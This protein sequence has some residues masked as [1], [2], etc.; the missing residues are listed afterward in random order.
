MADTVEQFIR[1]I[2]PFF[3][4]RNVTYVDVGAFDGAVSTKFL[5]SSLS[6]GEAHLIE[7]NPQSFERLK[8]TMQEMSGIGSLN[9]YNT[10]IGERQTTT[11]M[12]MTR[13][14]GTSD[15]PGPEAKSDNTFEVECL[16]LDEISDR[17]V[18]GEI[19]ILKV[20]VEGLERNALAGARALL[21]EGRVDVLYI[22]AGAD[23]QGT[24]RCFYRDINDIMLGHDYRIFRIYEQ[25]HDWIED[26][27][28]LRRMSIAYLS[29]R[30]AE[31][32]PYRLTR[33][34]FDAQ[35]A[36]EGAR[37]DLAAES[38][39]ATQL[40][41]W[42]KK[43]KKQ[44]EQGVAASKQKAA[45]LHEQVKSQRAA[46][47]AEAKRTAQLESG[48]IKL[49]RL[50][51][52]AETL[53]KSKASTLQ[54]K[55]AYGKDTIEGLKKQAD[56]DRQAIEALAETARKTKVRARNEVA[57]LQESLARKE[58]R[59]TELNKQLERK[60]AEVQSLKAKIDSIYT[61]VSWRLAAPVRVI[62]GGLRR[63]RPKGPKKSKAIAAKSVGTEPKSKKSV[64]AV[65]GEAASTVAE[66]PFLNTPK[67]EKSTA[68]KQKKPV[69][70]GKKGS[71]SSHARQL[72]D[73]LWGGFSR[74]ALADLEAVKRSSSTNTAEIADAAKAL[75]CWY[76]A[77]NDFPRGRENAALARSILNDKARK[78]HVLVE[79]HCLVR[80][81]DGA[82][83]RQLL[84][85]LLETYPDDPNVLFA[86][87]STYIGSD[88]SSDADD[89]RLS[90]INR[91]YKQAN[92]LPLAK[93]DAGGALTI[94]NLT[95]PEPETVDH[96]AKV[97]IIVPAF[98]AAAS[99]TFTLD[100]IR[101]QS[102]RNI[103]VLV[104]DDCSADETLSVAEAYAEV[105][106]R[107]R[108]AR[109]DRNQG[110][111]VARNKA[112]ELAVGDFVT[113]HD[114]G[115]WSHPQKIEIQARHLLD[116]ERVIANHTKW[117]RAFDNLFFGG[118]FRRKDKILDWN[119][120]SVFFRRELLEKVSGWDG[121][122][123]SADAEFV[124]RIQLSSPGHSIVS[125]FDAAP[126]ALGLDTPSSLT[127]ASAT[128]G[129]TIYHGLRREYREASD[130]WHA[131]ASPDALGLDT[132]ARTRPFPAP[133]AI[134]P[135]RDI[136]IECDVVLI[137]DFN[138][139]DEVRERA[140]DHVSRAEAAG[141]SMA[142][143][144]WKQYEADPTKPLAAQIR[145][146]AFDGRV[147]IIAPGEEVRT[148][149]LVV[150]SPSV[151][152]HMIDL[153]PRIEFKELLVLADD[154]EDIDTQ[155]DEN[156][157]E[158][159]GAVGRRIAAS[160]IDY[161]MP[162]EVPLPQASSESDTDSSERVE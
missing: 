144:H 159:F 25:T 118:K 130:H 81:G 37:S 155:A 88:E 76:T 11:T 96:D 17:F 158:A 143:F 40:E 156:R 70:T 153:T 109:L 77:E 30:F 43:L 16:T 131:Q 114:T 148:R 60:S 110:S 27:P 48:N 29:P 161:G 7:P 124:R 151:T 100:S 97:S 84:A 134:L 91:V 47:S 119:P 152:R 15:S 116:N 20:D 104:V 75:A 9:L 135:D 126:L 132:K 127:K 2:E 122:R 52:R 34:L 92:L 65:V 14:I 36:L 140:R 54:V 129:R 61:S 26:S 8:Q 123:I 71:R 64:P 121:T 63:L 160:E 94:A 12:K 111:Y 154:K 39:R 103:E 105:D 128:H 59:I 24:Q 28:L 99:L 112:L 4:R 145:Q 147:R 35:R 79:A 125:A 69:S 149:L 55:L 66:V 90:W 57:R 106:P 141:R 13:V 38:K 93:A 115:D 82:S 33:E 49:N 53:W 137:D 87:A 107:F 139:S 3:Y 136:P 80:M 72:D 50:L 1:D 45:V 73:R 42:N 21:A 58:D 10:A 18:N 86:M 85:P 150:G 19:S 133:G 67:K 83:A 142:L 23:P 108:V 74:Y 102:W 6:I 22:E 95:T 157:R 44:F 101:R 62:S 138:R 56:E 31:I 89:T 113:V 162:D 51:A 117:A 5:T 146:L 120:S 78:E 46:L 32:H 98:N 41:S 68:A